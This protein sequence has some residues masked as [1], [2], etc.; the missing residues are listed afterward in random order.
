[1]TPETRT[2]TVVADKTCVD[3]VEVARAA[4]VAVAGEEWVGEHLGFEPEEERVGTHRFASRQPGYRGWHWAVTVARASRG[5]AATVDE[6]CLLPGGEAL[7]APAWV[8]YEQRLQP[9][10]LGVGDV[11]PTAP[12][13]PRLE[14][15][16]TGLGGRHNGEPDDERET[17][18]ELGLGRERVLSL[19]GIDDAADRWLNGPGGPRAPIAE[20]APA[21]CTTCGFLV[22]VAGLLGQAFG[23]CANEYSPSDGRVVTFDH[24]CGAHSQVAVASLANMAAGHVIDEVGYDELGQ[25]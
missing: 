10:D 8:P 2:R 18:R 12:D 1:M 20:A 25:R 4:A 22:R 6:V 21:H 9:G 16:Y 7:L 14:P 19:I 11:L 15:G 23:V 3:A 13:D 24:G 5:K 17:A